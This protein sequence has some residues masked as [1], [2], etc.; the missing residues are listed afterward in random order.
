[1]G[2]S[3][4]LISVQIA[5]LTILSRLL[6]PEDFGLIGMALVVTGFVRLFSDIGL[7]AAT[8][9][10][11]ELSERFVN[12]LFYIDLCAATILMLF[13][14]LVAPVAAM[15]YSEPRVVLIIMI[16]AVTFPIAALRG[17]HQ[18]LMARRMLYLRLNLVQVS[19]AI[20]GIITAVGSAWT[21]ELGFWSIV[22]GTLAT[23]TSNMLLCWA[24]SPW[25]P[26][27][28]VSWSEAKSAVSF[29]LNLLGANLAGWIW[30]QSDN[31][32]IGYR[33]DAQELGFYARAYSI[34]M[35]PLSLVS[36]PI[37]SAVIPAL[38][39]LQ[40]KKEDWTAL[41]FST[42]RL[43]S[44][45]AGLVT[46]GLALNAEFIVRLLLG[47]DWE[48][49]ST[50]F[51]FLAFSIVPNLIWELAR[52]IFLSLGR[53]D[54]MFRYAMLAAS[55]HVCACVVGVRYGAE[56]VAVS[57]AIVSWLMTPA[58]L[59]ISSRIA[60]ISP[61]ALTQQILP[62]ICAMTSIW[63]TVAIFWEFNPVNSS[64]TETLLKN[65]VLAGV[66][67]LVHVVVLPF[68]AGWRHDCERISRLARSFIERRILA[69]SALRR[70][71]D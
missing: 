18:A 35:V 55:F 66:Y 56:G 15:I 27:R 59:M 12:S 46:V 20:V 11:D 9:Q 3:I 68:H 1:M 71:W 36:G 44:F 7:S 16:I 57:L 25:R 50:I 13:C 30:K 61:W 32:L 31:A 63:A 26:S 10:R 28:S 2:A 52:F 39:R 62:S 17:Q 53:T 65:A 60:E 22:L 33:W 24:M 69:G 4:I 40:N 43:M 41:L 19:S 8:I 38:S 54:V 23:S 37:G 21:F 5:Q 45:F 34:L 6:K 14:W 58:L 48:R 64:F 51:Y 67:V 70:L 47:P 29:G 42:A 49:S